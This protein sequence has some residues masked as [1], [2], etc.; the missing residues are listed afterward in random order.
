MI[1]LLFLSLIITIF[2][3]SSSSLSN[4]VFSPYQKNLDTFTLTP[5]A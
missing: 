3:V 1:H 5:N 2:E 4:E